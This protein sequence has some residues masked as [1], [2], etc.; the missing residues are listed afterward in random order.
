MKRTMKNASWCV[1]SELLKAK[2]SFT[3]WFHSLLP[4]RESGLWFDILKLWVR[5]TWADVL[6]KTRSPLIEPMTADIHLLHK[7]KFIPWQ[8]VSLPLRKRSSPWKKGFSANFSKLSSCWHLFHICSYLFLYLF[9]F[10]RRRIRQI[11]G[12]RKKG[13]RYISTTNKCQA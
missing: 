2:R 5:T 4:G 9:N 11:V 8:I 3:A 6:E 13:V 10:I 12:R 1:E 7:R